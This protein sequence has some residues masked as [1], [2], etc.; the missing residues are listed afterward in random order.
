MSDQEAIGVI[1][2]TINYL[3]LMVDASGEDC[4]EASLIE[5][6]EHVMEFLRAGHA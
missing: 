5:Q 2:A 4:G 1:K 6:L 3:A